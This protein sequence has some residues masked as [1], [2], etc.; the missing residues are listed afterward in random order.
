M[1]IKHSLCGGL[2]TIKPCDG[3]VGMP[4]VD[5]LYFCVCG[6]VGIFSKS[7]VPREASCTTTLVFIPVYRGGSWAPQVRCSVSGRRTGWG[8]GAEPRPRPGCRLSPQ[9]CAGFCA[10]L[11]GVVRKHALVP[12]HALPAHPGFPVPLTRGLK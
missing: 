1:A 8:A 4:Q 11:D 6:C 3:H 10:S 12:G 7:W 5:I 2:L 9:G